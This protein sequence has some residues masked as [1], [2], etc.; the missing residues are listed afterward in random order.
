MEAAKILKDL[1]DD[2]NHQWNCANYYSIKGRSLLFNKE[3]PAARENLKKA[4]TRF[5]S[6]ELYEPAFHCSINILRTL[7]SEVKFKDIRKI[8]EV[9][10][11]SEIFF[12]HYEKFS[13]TPGYIETKLN[14]AK[15][16]SL[17]YRSE[18]KFEL[19][20]IWSKRSYKIAEEGYKL[21]KKEVFRKGYI[22]NTH[23]YW[24]IRAKR[25]EKEHEYELAAKFYE[26]AAII[27][28]GTKKEYCYQEYVNYHKCL[29]IAN[30]Y[31]E[32]L[33]EENINKA[34]EYAVK[35]NDENQINY[36]KGFKFEGQA[37]LCG[38]LEDK[39]EL[40]EKAKGH[41]FQAHSEY[42]G[43]FV[44]YTLSYYLSKAELKSGNYEK[45]IS[46]LKRA[47]SYSEYVNF[48]NIIS[49]KAIL[50]NELCLHQ[51]Y[52]YLSKGDL[53]NSVYVLKNW[54]LNRKDIEGTN[55]YSFY[56][57]LSRCLEK[58]SQENDYSINDLFELNEILENVKDKKLGI[59][60]YRICSITYS[61][62]SL[63][64]NDVKN[65]EIFERIKLDIISR[66][67]TEEA[68]SYVARSLKSQ[69]AIEDRTW[70]LKLPPKFAEKFDK[71][72]FILNDI[73]EGYNYLA[74]KEFYNLLENILKIVIKFNAKYLWHDK[75]EMELKEK[76]NNDKEFDHF[77]FGDLIDSLVCIKDSDGKFCQEI[78]DQ[79]IELLKKHLIIR[80]KLTHDLNYE[81]DDDSIDILKDSTEIIQSLIKGFPTHIKVINISKKPWYDIEIQWNNFPKRISIYSEYE[82]EKDD[83]YLEPSIEVFSKLYPQMIINAN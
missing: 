45:S 51:S 65:D 14:F 66:I 11:A 80:N 63:W 4:E 9:I 23:F 20:E 77:T 76:I 18:G 8:Q 12:D 35:Y 48:P 67:T 41:Y 15:I 29:A 53:L 36:L 82:L 38:Q 3:Y 74:Y 2:R 32:N 17:K 56:E 75:F 70:L 59:I 21:H 37:R 62:L 33:F 7:S 42:S 54:L 24:Q 39:I 25:L 72:V 40:L 79:S 10:E 34:I 60:L 19:A 27:I 13:D 50:E 73:M 61:Y 28:S 44:E 52:L 49:S 78:D 1:N 68:A 83:Y 22:F 31:D 71:C 64:I 55:K 47:I 6:I 58:L 30:R 57:I 43:K 69:S 46:F 81:L 5:L 26:K 16:N